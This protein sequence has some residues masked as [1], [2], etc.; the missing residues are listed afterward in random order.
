[1]MWTNEIL[2]EDVEQIVIENLFSRFTVLFL[3]RL[4]CVRARANAR[5][6]VPRLEEHTGIYDLLERG[7]DA[8]PART[9]S[10]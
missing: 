7:G 9:G 8:S 6:R 4:V 10:E 2:C 5:M 3:T 1:M